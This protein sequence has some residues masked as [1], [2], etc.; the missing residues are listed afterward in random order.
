MI[1]NTYNTSDIIAYIKSK[2]LI[3]QDVAIINQFLKECIL[4][5]NHSS[6]Q[7]LFKTYCASGNDPNYIDFSIIQNYTEMM[8]TL[9]QAQYTTAVHAH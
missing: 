4:M 3:P 7:T 1:T 9:K 2:H 8:Y 6:I 5:S